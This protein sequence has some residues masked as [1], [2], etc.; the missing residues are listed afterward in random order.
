[1]KILAT[2]RQK[3][4]RML[5]RKLKKKHQQ[6][7]DAEQDLSMQDEEMQYDCSAPIFP[8]S[9]TIGGFTPDD[10]NMAKAEAQQEKFKNRRRALSKK[11]VA[12]NIIKML[13]F[14]LDDE[15]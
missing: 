10:V 14:E 9:D 4:F 2:H 13:D 15:K 1:M 8:K 11:Q 7:T 6:A 3:Y 5:I 12:K